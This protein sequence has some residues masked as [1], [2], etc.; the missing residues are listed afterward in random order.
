MLYL[1]FLIGYDSLPPL[2]DLSKLDFPEPVLWM[3]P[4]AREI[5]INGFAGHFYGAELDLNLHS[6]LGAGYFIRKNEWDSTDAGSI[7]LSYKAVMPRLW[8]KPKVWAHLL[9][10]EDEYQQIMPGLE[11]ALF[12][13]PLIATGS[14]N[15]SRWLING[16]D[17]FEA[18]GELNLTFDRTTYLPGITVNGIYTEG[19][20]KPN[21]FANLHLHTIHIMVGSAIKTGFPSPSLDIAYKMPWIEIAANAQTGVKHNALGGYFNPE[22]PIKYRIDIPAETLRVDVG[23]RLQLNMGDQCYT[24]AGSHKQWMLRLVAGQVYE[25]AAKKDIN[26]TNLHVIARNRLTVRSVEV[27]N[28][29]H[30]HYN[31][32]DSAI[33]FLPDIALAD[34]LQLKIGFI[35]L[36]A[37]FR[38]AAQRNGIEKTLP[39]YHTIN[40]TLGF[41]LSAVKLYFAVH[42]L[43]DDRAEIYDDYYL[44]GRQYAGG[45]EVEQHF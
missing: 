28:A 21:M 17:S 19:E 6:F 40:T 32:S 23:L 39:S 7:E 41:R 43:T 11:F 27:G 33:P 14:V 15:Y 42:N 2:P 36:S 44:T 35:E 9:R 1:L 8:L 16:E 34:T 37:D 4:V 29:L 13:S 26:E 10:R 31:T 24:L 25:I 5:R 3:E 20:L 38:Y 18:D 22:I 45:I 30:V 12:T